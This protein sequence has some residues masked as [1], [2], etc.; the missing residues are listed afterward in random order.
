MFLLASCLIDDLY[1]GAVSDL[2][3]CAAQHR[4]IAFSDSEVLTL[5]ADALM[6]P[7]DVH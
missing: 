6:Q 4:R 1:R 3:A 7:P 2:S 5:C